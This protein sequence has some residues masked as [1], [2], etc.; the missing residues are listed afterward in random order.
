NLTKCRSKDSVRWYVEHRGCRIELST[1]ELLNPTL[2]QKV[3]AERFTLLIQIGK[4]STW[5]KRLQELMQTCEEIQDPD[6]AREQGQFENL[7][8]NFF[9]FGRM[10]RNKDELIKGNAFIENGRVL[11]RSEDLLQYLML[12]RFQYT[13]H[14]VWMWLKQ[15]GATAHRTSLRDKDLRV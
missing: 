6:D 12:R 2:L 10:G 8:D 13:P 9:S 7:V 3:F 4:R 15:M 1:D 5:M 11:F 14:K